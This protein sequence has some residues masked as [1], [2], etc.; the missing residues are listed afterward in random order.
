MNV[1]GYSARSAERFPCSGSRQNALCYFLWPE[2][3]VPTGQTKSSFALLGI[4]ILAQVGP[5]RTNPFLDMIGSPAR[6]VFALR[7]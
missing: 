4:P 5:I 6:V 1:D 7:P 2:E 3:R